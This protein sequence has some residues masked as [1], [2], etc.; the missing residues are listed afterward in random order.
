MINL[1]ETEEIILFKSD[2]EKLSKL[3]EWTILSSS[4]KKLKKILYKGAYTIAPIECDVIGYIE[5]FT[6]PNCIDMV[7]ETAVI[8]IGNEIHK[9][10]PMYLKDMQKN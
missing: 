10:N 4:A 6:N 8:K 5:K 7:Y 9:I 1:N 2:T 3:K